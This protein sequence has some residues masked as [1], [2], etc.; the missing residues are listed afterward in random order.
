MNLKVGCYQKRGRGWLWL[1]YAAIVHCEE[2]TAS[3][4]PARG[5]EGQ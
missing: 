2:T 5:L 3:I 4:S 1:D